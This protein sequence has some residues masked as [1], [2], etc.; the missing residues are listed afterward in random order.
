MFMSDQ[1][2]LDF[3]I[4]PVG[5]VQLWTPDQ[6]YDNLSSETL[7]DFKEDR[8]IERKANKVQP[9]ALAEYL[10]MWSNTQP[11]GGIILV[12]VTNDGNI[13]GCKSLGTDGKNKLEK[14]TRLCPDAHW[15]CK[16]IAVINMKG[17]DDF[18]LVYRVQ[19]RADKL[20]L[21]TGDEAFIREGDDKLK[22]NETMKRELRISKGEIH[23]ELEPCALDYPQDF[24]LSEINKFCRAYFSNR[25]MEA[26]KSREE[27]LILAKLGKIIDGNFRPNLACALLF[28]TDPRD[29][30]PGARLRIIKYEGEFEK[31]GREMNSTFSEYIDGPI[32]KLIFEARPII[33]SQLRSFQKLD[34]SGKLRRISE[35][36]E[37]AWLEAVVNAVAHRSYNLKTQ[38]IFVKIFDDKFV[39]ESPG[40]FVPPTTGDTVYNAHNPRNPFLM[41]AMMHLELTFCAHEGTRR[42]KDAME[43]ASLPEPRFRQIEDLSHQVHVLLENNIDS[44]RSYVENQFDRLISE[45]EFMDLTPDERSLLNYFMHTPHT[46]ITH[47][48]LH[49]KKS[50]PTAQKAMNG[51]VERKLVQIISKRGRQRDP[52]KT[53]RLSE[54]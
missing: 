17:E 30:I 4:K 13:E 8:R 42:M 11:H 25:R 48:A 10:S 7:K 20:V 35:Y 52:S 16:E 54:E 33:A 44:R 18:L 53:Y 50:W 22:I 9:K 49:L 1:L 38:N 5:I 47:A 2:Y 41:E 19:Y 45:K 43:R 39:V 51:L 46:N 34:A 12:G 31:F 40:G 28:S 14:L 23:Y 24:D 6:I 21:T 32:S 15:A 36:P 27:I 26:E 37:E 3:D 29:V